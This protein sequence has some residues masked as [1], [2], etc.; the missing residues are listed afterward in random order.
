M[1][2]SLS[3]PYLASNSGEEV[4]GRGHFFA[5]SSIDKI[6]LTNTI[7]LETTDL[8]RKAYQTLHP[9][10]DISLDFN[11]LS[12]GKHDEELVFWLV[13]DSFCRLGDRKKIYPYSVSLI[14]KR[15]DTNLYQYK[16]LLIE[17]KFVP[18]ADWEYVTKNSEGAVVDE[19]WWG[20]EDGKIS[21]KIYIAQFLQSKINRA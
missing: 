5:S 20:Y 18:P 11:A 3:L 2:Y 1:R 16:D 15:G 13:E 10:I 12:Y 8:A 21:I 6:I 9:L 19:T 17:E 14:G 4:N 7:L